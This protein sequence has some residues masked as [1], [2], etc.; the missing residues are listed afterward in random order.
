VRTSR[1]FSIFGR[2]Y[3]VHADEHH[4]LQ[5]QG[6]DELGVPD[7]GLIL[8][9]KKIFESDPH[10]RLGLDKYIAYLAYAK[11]RRYI[12]D[13][14]VAMQLFRT[15]IELLLVLQILYCK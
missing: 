7:E 8:H 5:L 4:V 2:V 15:I 10:M 9:L 6:L 11:T 12:T 13:C 14:D 3:D 1:F